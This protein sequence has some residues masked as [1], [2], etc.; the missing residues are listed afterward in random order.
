MSAFDLIKNWQIV[1]EFARPKILGAK[2]DNAQASRQADPKDPTDI[3]EPEDAP[4]EADEE[5][6]N[7]RYGPTK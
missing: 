5:Q 4:F 3:P 2:R 6:E 7:K 1:R